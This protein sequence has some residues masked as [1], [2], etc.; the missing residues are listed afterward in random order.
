MAEHSA[1]PGAE[2]LLYRHSRLFDR[3]ALDSF[4]GSHLIRD[5]RDVVVS[6]YHYHL[7]TDEEWVHVPSPEYGGMTYQQYLRSLDLE[8]GMAAEIRRSAGSDLAEMGQWTYAQPEF[9]EL[10]Y[11]DFIVDEANHF[12]RI[13]RHYGFKPAAVERSVDLALR[14]S[15]Q[16]M[17][18]RS[19]GQ[20]KEGSH[21]RSGKPGQWREV[22]SPRNMALF[23]ELTGDLLERLGY[24]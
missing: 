15:F 4:R 17:A 8:A 14:F 16:R 12:G 10:R 5:P 7:W 22:L 9:L 3:K 18:G 19:I 23:R 20:V 2:I 13:F 11:E 21:L 24:V 6:G 1:P